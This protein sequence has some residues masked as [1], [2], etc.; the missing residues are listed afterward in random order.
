MPWLLIA[1][2]TQAATTANPV[3]AHNSAGEP[4]RA[5]LIIKFTETQTDVSSPAVLISLSGDAGASLVYVRAMATGAHV[6]VV[7]GVSSQDE[8][9]HVIRRLAMRKDVVYV[10][11]DRRIRHQRQ[12]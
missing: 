9:N 7:E 5:Q 4:I 3:E 10:E 8:L 6:F 12:K 11:R 2:C 1:A